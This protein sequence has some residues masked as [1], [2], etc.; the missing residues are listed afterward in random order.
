MKNGKLKVENLKWSEVRS[1]KSE[2]RRREMDVVIVSVAWQSPELMRLLHFIRNDRSN[3]RIDLE[4]KIEDRW[5]M[6]EE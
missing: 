5:P 3:R 6:T 1:Q 4:W 2:D